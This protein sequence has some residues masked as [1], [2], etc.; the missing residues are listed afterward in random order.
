MAQPKPMPPLERAPA[1][2]LVPKK[3]DVKLCIKSYKGQILNKFEKIGY[4]LFQWLSFFI[5]HA[6]RNAS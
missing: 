2:S 4:H 1:L 3:R 5:D 6:L